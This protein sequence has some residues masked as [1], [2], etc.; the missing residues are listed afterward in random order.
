MTP[1]VGSIKTQK[2]FLRKVAL[3]M[4][5]NSYKVYPDTYIDDSNIFLITAVRNFT[6]VVHI[7][8]DVTQFCYVDAQFFSKGEQFFV[9]LQHE[10]NDNPHAYVN[11]RDFQKLIAFGIHRTY[12]FSLLKSYVS[13]LRKLGCTKIMMYFMDMDKSESDLPLMLRIIHPEFGQFHACLA[14]RI[15]ETKEEELDESDLAEMY[16]PAIEILCKGVK[17]Y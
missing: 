10:Q 14:P 12:N 2:A 8:Y 16:Q 1:K 17:E 11:Q 7:Q 6:D 5:L 13:P 4:K 3:L 15:V 9:E